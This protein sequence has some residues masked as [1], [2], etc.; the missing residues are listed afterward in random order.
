MRGMR[1]YL[2]GHDMMMILA[3]AVVEKQLIFSSVI[4]LAVN[5][6]IYYHVYSISCSRP[7]FVQAFCTFFFKYMTTIR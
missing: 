1:V 4:Y 3:L 7:T 5:Y 2:I 6:T